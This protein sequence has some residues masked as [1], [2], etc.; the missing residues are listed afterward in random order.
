[1]WEAYGLDSDEMLWAGT[2][3]FGGVAGYN[4]GPCGVISAMAVCLGTRYRVS[5]DD[6]EKA[7]WA[8][9]ESRKKTGELIKSFK[10]EFGTIIC[11]DLLGIVGYIFRFFKKGRF[12]NQ[13]SSYVQ[14]VV[15]KL[16]ELD[17][18]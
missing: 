3:F 7:E 2:S 6:K 14:F 1:M 13:C 15:E 9:E 11:R 16:Y 8:R 17:E 4:E 18:S 5:S 12:R 10:D